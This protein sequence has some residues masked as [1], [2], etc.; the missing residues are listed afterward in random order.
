LTKVKNQLMRQVVTGSMSVANKARLLGNAVLIHGDPDHV[1]RRLEEIRGVSLEDVQRVARTYLALERRTEVRVEPSIGGMLKNMLGFGKGPVEDEGAAEVA[2]SG[3]NRIAQRTGVK[4]TAVRPADFP[5]V[6][7]MKPL[8][9]EIPHVRSVEKTLP[10]GLRVVVIPNDEIPFVTM[11]LGLK[12]GAWADDASRP[13]VASMALQ[14]LTQGTEKHSAVELAEE[15]EYNALTL[16]GGAGLDVARVSATALADKVEKAVELLAEVVLRP[17]FPKDQFSV[18]KKQTSMGLMISSKEP[19]YIANREWR[20][21]LYGDHPYARTATGEL[22]DVRRIKPEHVRAWWSTFARPDA[23]VLYVAGD[24]KPERIFQLVERHLG[25][26]TA[27]GAAPQPAV[28]EAPSSDGTHI[29][30]VDRPGSVQSQIRVGH[31]GIT[32]QHPRY[33]A[34]RVFN[35]IFGGAFNSR[36][37]EAIRVERGL[38]YGARGGFSAR[39]FAGEFQASTFSKTPKT[40]EAI[41][42][43]LDVIKGMVAQPATDEELDIARNYLAGSFAGDRETPQATVSD[44][45]LI[46]YAGLPSDY[47]QQALKAYKRTGE[48]DVTGIAELL[49]DSSRMTIIVVGDAKRIKADLEKIAPVTLV[50]EEQLPTKEDVS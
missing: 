35:Q 9:E 36:L 50:K 25:G 44:L 37:N 16:S 3:E 41:Q 48:R 31:A 23:A 34:S 15:I 24:A 11:T 38:T 32:R 45:W 12:Y 13:G 22:Q 46:E 29:Y 39:R 18:L 14:M 42:V 19:N 47:F 2:A 6:P 4:A 33:H 43:L 49:I 20:R 26:W 1:N 30:L 5:S 27:Q 40:A 8:L 7:P 10:N 28:V 21:R 17:T